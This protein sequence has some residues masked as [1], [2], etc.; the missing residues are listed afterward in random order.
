MTVRVALILTGKLEM[1]GLAKGLAGLFGEEHEFVSIPRRRDQPDEPFPGFTSAPLPQPGQR[2]PGSALSN[3]V[4]AMVDAL[5]TH[6]YDLAVV[7]DD[8][9]LYNVGN[10]HIVVDEF[11]GAVARHLDRVVQR[12]AQLGRELGDR[13]RASGS[14]HLVSPMI[15]SWIFADPGGAA[16][17]GVPSRHLPPRLVQGQDPESLV[18]N[19]PAYTA[20]VGSACTKWMSLPSSY[21]ERQRPEW[22][23]T[24]HPRERHPKRYLAWLCRDP[25]A[26]NCSTFSER[27]ACNALIRLSWAQVLQNPR[28]MTF[29]RALVCDLA[30]G[31]GCAPADL[32]LT[33]DEAPLTSIHTPRSEPVLRNL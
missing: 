12:D 23:K 22:L 3:L 14:F 21:Q 17:A 20:D 13:L 6:G 8:V 29:A 16:N 11:R 30:D 5:W 31:L 33:G 4:A 2:E 27:T 28:H 15:E 32:D 25:A 10:E 26:R 9:E 1:L 18:T 19:D 24:T 7:L